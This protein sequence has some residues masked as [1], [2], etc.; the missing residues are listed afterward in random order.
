MRYGREGILIALNPLI[1]DPEKSPNIQAG[2]EL[3]PYIR[4]SITTPDG[5][6]YSL[7][8]FSEC[9]HCS[10]AQKAWINTEWL[11]ALGLDMPGTTAELETVLEA[12][13]T[14]DPNGNGQAG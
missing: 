1:D 10:V 2:F 3:K 13:Q 12:F 11:D 7:P 6:I 4:P 8:D 14:G 5:N 9:Y